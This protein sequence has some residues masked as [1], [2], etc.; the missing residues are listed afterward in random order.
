[1]LETRPAVVVAFWDLSGS[2]VDG[3]FLEGDIIELEVADITISRE[4]HLQD[5]TANCNSCL[6]LTALSMGHGQR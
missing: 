4:H 5:L 2:V 6:S 3:L 1:V